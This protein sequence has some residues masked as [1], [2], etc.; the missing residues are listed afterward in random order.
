MS[1]PHGAP[2]HAEVKVRFADVDAARLAFYPRIFGMF[3]VAFERLFE[4]RFGIR[5]ADVIEKDRIGFP[6]VHVE[7]D[8]RAPL[9]FGDVADVEIAVERLGAKSTTLRYRMTRQPSALLCVEAT[10][11]IVTVRVDDNSP[12]AT[13]D[14]YRELFASIARGPP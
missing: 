9:R 7:C 13:P 6:T 14:R 5:Y 2:F 1:D 8:F 10:A 11:T 12:M 3:H 4:E